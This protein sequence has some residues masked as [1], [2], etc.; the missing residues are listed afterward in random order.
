MV[1]GTFDLLL[2]LLHSPLLLQSKLMDQTERQVG[3]E[4][5]NSNSAQVSW[6]HGVKS[7]KVV[8]TWD[9]TQ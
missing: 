9:M 5:W 1:Q 4:I 3:C 8:D 2:L 6:W 7:L